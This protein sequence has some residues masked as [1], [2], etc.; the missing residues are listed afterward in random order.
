[1]LVIAERHF[2]V[3]Q[4]TLG[5]RLSVTATE[6]DMHSANSRKITERTVVVRLDVE[7]ATRRQLAS[8]QN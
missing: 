4:R 1:M 7:A 3:G 6:L 5:G 2:P 8:C